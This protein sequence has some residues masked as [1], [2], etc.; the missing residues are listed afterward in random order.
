MIIQ[1]T[2]ISLKKSVSQIITN[3]HKLYYR[4]KQYLTLKWPIA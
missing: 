3:N 4:T 1:L 2:P